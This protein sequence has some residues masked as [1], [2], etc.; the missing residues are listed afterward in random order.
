[1]TISSPL[2]KRKIT[3]VGTV[4]KNKPELQPALLSTRG[5]EAFTAGKGTF[6]NGS[7]LPA[8]QPLQRL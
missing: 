7:A 3:M 2:M 6:K 8:Q 4:R 5:R 1:M